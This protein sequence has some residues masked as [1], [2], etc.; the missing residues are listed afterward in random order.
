MTEKQI[1]DNELAL[2]IAESFNA[3]PE[4]DHKRL[5]IIEQNLERPRQHRN[6]KPW[7]VA[8]LLLAGAA[9]ASW[10]VYHERGHIFSTESTVTPTRPLPIGETSR[11][12]H[13]QEKSDPVETTKQP[14]QKPVDR[15]QFH[16]NGGQSPRVIYSR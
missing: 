16:A 14:D 1:S 7:W 10:Y 2:L 15:E 13:K 9:A 11:N 3:L 5:L 4:P 8:G 6:R 12:N